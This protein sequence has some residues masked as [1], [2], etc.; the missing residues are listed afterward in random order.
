MSQQWNIW[1]TL[2]DLTARVNSMAMGLED[3][4]YWRHSV[5]STCFHEEPR[6]A[7]SRHEHNLASPLMVACSTTDLHLTFLH[8]LS[9]GPGED[10]KCSTLNS[11]YLRTRSELLCS[12]Q[13]MYKSINLQNL[14]E[15]R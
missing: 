11:V 3:M 13:V 8:D 15:N 9:E 12:S 2:D 5:R 14:N 1:A 6:G 10:G 7:H 4:R